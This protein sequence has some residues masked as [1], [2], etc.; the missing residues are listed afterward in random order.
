ML[1]LA[2][3]V[4][5]AQ[6]T[7]APYQAQIITPAPPAHEVRR[8]VR[9]AVVSAAHGRAVD[10]NVAGR[11]ALMIP[12][13]VNTYRSTWS[14][15]QFLRATPGANF[16]VL[17]I[18]KDGTYVWPKNE[19]TFSGRVSLYAPGNCENGAGRLHVVVRDGSYSYYVAREDADVVI[20]QTGIGNGVAIGK[21]R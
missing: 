8:C 9:G 5:L 14:D 21:R 17:T 13:A 7:I 20:Y 2:L 4:L 10:R 16:G 1:H 12:G 11:W 18:H 15:L 3:L 6:E 19:G